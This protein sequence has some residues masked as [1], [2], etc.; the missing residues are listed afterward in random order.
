M[1]IIL[2]FNLISTIYGIQRW[3]PKNEMEESER[4]RI[5]VGDQWY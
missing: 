2:I 1:Y 5:A 4:S 3:K